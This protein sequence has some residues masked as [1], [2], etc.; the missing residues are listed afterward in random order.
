LFCLVAV[1]MIHDHSR[2]VILNIGQ[3]VCSKNNFTAVT[4]PVTIW[5]LYW[6][7]STVNMNIVV[8]MKCETKLID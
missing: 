7:L 6:K 1:N 4:F 5:H 2:D 8:V 3:Q